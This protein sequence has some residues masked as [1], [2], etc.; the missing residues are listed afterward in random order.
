MTL[1][2]S[3][4]IKASQINTELGLSSSAQTNIGG[5]SPRSWAGKASGVI[6][7][8]DFYGKAKNISFNVSLTQCM[9]HYATIFYD[10]AGNFYIESRQPDGSI[11]TDR[12]DCG[13]NPQG[14]ILY[15]SFSTS[16]YS[17][18]NFSVYE[19]GRNG[20]ATYT[21]TNWDV[22]TA[23][24]DNLPVTDTSGGAAGYYFNLYG[25]VS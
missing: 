20:T 4:T 25:T 5:A 3:G 15:Y 12:G 21:G 13:S 18:I 9:D 1:P 16:G 17:V 6:K 24:R 14:Q 7:Y 10:G 8:S 22:N 11:H 19:S 2:A 23:R